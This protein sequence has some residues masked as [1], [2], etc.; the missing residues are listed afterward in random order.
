LLAVRWMKQRM[1]KYQVAEQVNLGGE[2]RG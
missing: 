2:D 1:F